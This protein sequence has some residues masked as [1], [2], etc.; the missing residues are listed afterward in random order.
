MAV[1]LYSKLIIA[2]TAFTGEAAFE[3]PPDLTLVVRDM[4]ATIKGPSL[5]GT[6][7]AYDTDGVIFW[8]DTFA[9]ITLLL[10]WT[11]WRGRQVIPGPGFFYMSTTADMSIRASGYLLQGVSP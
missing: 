6:V 2:N 4:D 11:S 1:P 3:I 7:W 8:A 10:D 9:T 5:G